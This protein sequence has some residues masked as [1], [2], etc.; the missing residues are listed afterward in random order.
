MTRVLIT[1]G[2]SPADAARNTVTAMKIRYY[3]AKLKRY[4]LDPLFVWP[5]MDLDLRTLYGWCD[6]VLLTGGGDFDGK[7]FG[8]ETHPEADLCHPG[9]DEMEMELLEYVFRDRKPVLGICRGCQAL[10]IA[11]GG[12][13]VQ[14]IPDLGL[15]ERHGKSEHLH[16]A[17]NMV[18]VIDRHDV[19]LKE[20]SRA[21]GLVG[22]E[23]VTVNSF[24]HQMVEQPGKGLRIVGRSPAGVTE[25]VE[26]EDERHF[27]FGIQSHPERFEESDLDVFF[28]KLATSR[29]P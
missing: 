6:C 22:K 25:L 27:C 17:E 1:F 26:S 13:L 3:V 23:R 28:E 11:R 19:V 10:A 4:G 9:R 24:H 5:G 14:H 15:E 20:D 7:W 29:S 18:A 21:Y 12:T 8:Q 16:T 2:N